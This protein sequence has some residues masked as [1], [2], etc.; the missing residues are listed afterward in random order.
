MLWGHSVI[1]DTV[2]ASGKT[3]NSEGLWKSLVP[4]ARS[5]WTRRTG[6]F[7]RWPRCARRIDACS[8]T[9]RR[10]RMLVRR[11]SIFRDSSRKFLRTILLGSAQ[12]IL[13]VEFAGGDL[14]AG[15]PG[16]G[17]VRR[18]L[19]FWG[20]P[21]SRLRLE[22]CSG[23]RWTMCMTGTSR[24]FTPASPTGRKIAVIGAGPAGL[25]CA[26]ELAR[27]GHTVTVFEKRDLPGGCRPMASSRCESRWTIALAEARM[28]AQLG[29]RIETGRELGGDLSLVELQQEFEMVILSVG[30]GSVR[31]SLAFRVKSMCSMGLSM[32]RTARWVRSR[33]GLAGRW[34]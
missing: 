24:L 5:E 28:I 26:G 4:T 7:R 29:V 3:V 34:L 30:L 12:T 23:M 19:V 9:T 32:S 17:V 25:S 1:T 16:A 6:R 14:C 2:A 10:V 33:S 13:E 11:T 8:A 20:R 31:R 18:E 22:G 21:M 27:R 15:V